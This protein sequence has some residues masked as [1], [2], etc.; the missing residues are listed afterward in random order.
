ASAPEPVGRERSKPG[1]VTAAIAGYYSSREFS[2][3]LAPS[4]QA[5]RKAVLEAFRREHGDKLMR[6]MPTKFLRALLDPM[7]A[8]TAKNRLAAI[9]ALVRYAIKADML[10]DHPTLGIRLRRM[11]GDGHHTWTEDELARFEAAHAIGTRERL[12]FAL[13]L[14]TGQRRGDVIRMGRQHI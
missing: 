2:K 13:G 8:T 9:R 10:D 3:G 14:H 7:E 12:A 11:G 1:S 4:S 5:V 6:A